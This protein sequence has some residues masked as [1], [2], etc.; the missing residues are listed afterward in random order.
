MRQVRLGRGPRGGERRAGGRS[1]R[2]P[3]KGEGFGS[4]GWGG[5]ATSTF[6]GG[7][8]PL[9]PAPRREAGDLRTP[10]PAW[11]SGCQTPPRAPR[12]PLLG[13]RRPAPRTCS[14]GEAPPRAPR[15]LLLPLG[16]RRPAPRT[17]SPWGGAAPRPAPALAGETPPRAPHL[18]PWGGAAPRP[19]PRAQHLLLLA[20][21][22]PAPRGPRGHPSAALGRAFSGRAGRAGPGCLRPPAPAR[23]RR[24]RRGDP[25]A[26]G[27]VPQSRGRRGLLRVRAGPACHQG[28]GLQTLGSEAARDAAGSGSAG[29]RVVPPFR[30]LYPKTGAQVA[31]GA[32]RLSRCCVSSAFQFRAR[33]PFCPVIRSFNNL[34]RSPVK[35]PLAPPKMT[36][37]GNSTVGRGLALWASVLLCPCTRPWEITLSWPLSPPLG[38][39]GSPAEG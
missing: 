13:R 7:H 25:G 39:K 30:S 35:S 3:G 2:G 31:C 10:R 8:P 36:R 32:R 5:E 34:D 33:R 4:P 27:W 38:T 12:L 20:R 14:P 37:E 19:A 16:R 24:R 9:H 23:R 1:R 28:A 21:R 22:R 26:A 18:P 15:L 17:C 6:R 11:A 29:G